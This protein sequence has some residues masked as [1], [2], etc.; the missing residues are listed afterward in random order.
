MGEAFE[1][2]PLVLEWYVLL[3]N[4]ESQRLTLPCLCSRRTFALCLISDEIGRH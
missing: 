4:I 1:R 3:G 2:H